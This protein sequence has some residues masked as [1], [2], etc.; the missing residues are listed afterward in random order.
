M[1][2]D[3]AEF[4]T[5]VRKGKVLGISSYHV[6]QGSFYTHVYMCIEQ[7]IYQRTNGPDYWPGITTA[8]KKVP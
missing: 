7:N 8:M 1:T 5:M 3:V 2:L 4:H 6:D